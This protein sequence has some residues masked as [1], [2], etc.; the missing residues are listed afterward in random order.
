VHLDQWL[1]EAY[2][3]E[4]LIKEGQDL[5][6]TFDQ[7]D[8]ADLLEIAC[9]QATVKVAAP[10]PPQ[11]QPVMVTKTAAAQPK[12]V[13]DMGKTSSAKF[14]FMDKIARQ[15]A[16][17]HAEVAQEL[18]KEAIL[19][20]GAV[21]Y[22]SQGNPDATPRSGFWRGVGGGMIGGA[23]GALPGILSKNRGLALAGSLAGQIGGG[24]LGGRTAK[25]TPEEMAAFKKKQMAKTGAA[26][27]LGRIE[28]EKE[29]FIADAALGAGIGAGV[30]HATGYGAA[31]GA[32]VGGL[33]GGGAGLGALTGF[34]GA[35]ALSR[36]AGGSGKHQLVHG[37]MGA[38]PGA[39]LGGAAGYKGGRAIFDKKS[40]SKDK[41]KESEYGEGMEK[42]DEFTSPEAKA[43]ANVMQKSMKI[44]KNAAPPVRKKAISEAAQ[45]LQR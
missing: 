26:R 27:L 10:Q 31:P 22:M 39:L 40:K 17:Q 25:A 14:K 44:A 16:R 23:A 13:K 20:P 34:H 11:P 19:L 21:G 3:E 5:E 29:A 24:Y 2:D 9:G 30:G 33:T 15:V 7:M 18:E 32:G 35:A 4:A 41:K 42:E 8:P 43:K 37:L 36:A 28:M 12:P 1:K 45:A 6:A 38:V